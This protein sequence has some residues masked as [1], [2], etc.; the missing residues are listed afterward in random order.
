M[1][2]LLKVLYRPLCF[3]QCALKAEDTPQACA[4]F[5]RVDFL[6]NEHSKPDASTATVLWRRCKWWEASCAG[7][8]EW[9]LCARRCACW[10]TRTAS[11]PRGWA[12][13]WSLPPSSATTAPSGSRLL[14]PMLPHRSLKSYTSLQRAPALLWCVCGVSR[15]SPLCGFPLHSQ[16]QPVPARM[17]DLGRRMWESGHRQVSRPSKQRHFYTARR[18]SAVIEDN[19]IKVRP[20]MAALA[21]PT[22]GAQR[23]WA[24]SSRGLSDSTFVALR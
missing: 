21:R 22:H 6:V 12:S 15:R 3:W 14:S 2:E 24:C 7:A 17:V 23:C 20:S 18:Y 19:K 10:R 5:M 1:V 13:L 4:L 8:E 16:I 11:W 9:R